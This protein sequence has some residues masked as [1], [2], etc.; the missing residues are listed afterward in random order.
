MGP[1]AR[2]STCLLPWILHHWLGALEGDEGKIMT[3]AICL[4][5]QPMPVRLWLSSC[6]G[7]S[8]S[9]SCQLYGPVHCHSSLERGMELPGSVTEASP[10]LHSFTGG[11]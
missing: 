5:G 8:R 1:E 7:A 11:N 9:P 3:L 6:Q 10:F 2:A 4:Q